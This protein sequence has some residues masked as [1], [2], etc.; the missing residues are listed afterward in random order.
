MAALILDDATLKQHVEAVPP[1]AAVVDPVPTDS[2]FTKK[3]TCAGSPLDLVMAIKHGIPIGIILESPATL[4]FV[5]D[6]YSQ[7][8][9]NC[10][11]DNI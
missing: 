10:E 8:I 6:P 9:F 5:P 2:P 1:A 3:A 7:N 4:V 11:V